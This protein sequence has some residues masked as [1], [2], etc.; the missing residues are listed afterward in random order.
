MV[1]KRT[2]PQGDWS[3]PLIHSEIDL[4]KIDTKP[5]A[6]LGGVSL[7]NGIDLVKTYPKSVNND[8]FLMF[9]QEL[10]DKFWLDDIVVIM[11]NLS[12]HKSKRSKERMDEMGFEYL[13][14]PPYSPQ[15]NPIEEVWSMIKRIIKKRRYDLIMKD[16]DFDLDNLV[17]QSFDKI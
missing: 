3:L 14:T 6:V 8:K 15:Y 7:E 5:I 11:D 9:L 1:T 16:Q 12:L 10:R 4:S 13:Y 2:I 17:K